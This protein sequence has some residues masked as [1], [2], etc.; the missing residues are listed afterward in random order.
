MRVIQQR[1]YC[2]CLWVLETR[3]PK[4]L[5]LKEMAYGYR[6]LVIVLWGTPAIYV[7]LQDIKNILVLLNT[8]EIFVQI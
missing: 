4:S 2:Y 3:E 5:H 8:Y 6:I 1:I 7:A